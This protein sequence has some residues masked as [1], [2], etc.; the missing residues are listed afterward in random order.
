LLAGG[1]EICL[2]QDLEGILVG[3]QVKYLVGLQL[4]FLILTNSEVISC[5]ISNTSKYGIQKA[6]LRIHEML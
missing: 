4:Q 2:E 3:R 6:V 5:C 1:K